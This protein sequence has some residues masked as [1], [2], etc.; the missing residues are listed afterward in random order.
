MTS[1][2]LDL[3]NWKLALFNARSSKS[4]GDLLFD[5][6]I[7]ENIILCNTMELGLETTMTRTGLGL[8]VLNSISIDINF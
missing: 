3:S 6:L 7:S 1:R 5:Y 4:N 8:K 2:E